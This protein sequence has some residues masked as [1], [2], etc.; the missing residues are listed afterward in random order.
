MLL[1]ALLMPWAANAQTR[2]T[3]TFDFEDGAIP[4]T[5][6]NDANYP[7]V[8]VSESQGSGHSGTYCIKS[9]NSGVNSSSST[10]SAT[11]NFNDDG[12]IS[13]LG[14]CFGEGSSTAW[15]KCIFSIDGAQQFAYGARQTW[16]TYTFNV[17][18]G[19]HTFTWSFTKDGSVNAAGDAFFVDDIVVDLGEVPAC[20][21]P[22]GLAVSNIDG[23]SATINWTSE[24]SAWVVAYK[25]ADATEFTEMD[26]TENPYTLT[27]LAPETVYQVKVQNN[28]GGGTYSLFTSPVSFTTDVACPAPTGLAAA[29]TLGNG[30]VATLSWTS[31][32]S[33]WVVAYKTAD[34]TDFTEVNVTE[35]PYTLT[36]LTPETTYNAKVKAVCG[37]ED[38][39]SSW[40][41]TITFTPTDAYTLTVNDGTTTNAYV[42]FYGYY[43]DSDANSQ[44]IIPADGLS[45]MAWG[46]IQKLTFYSSAASAVWNGAV[47]DIYFSE[48]DYTTFETAALIDWTALSE[49]VYTGSVSV[50]NGKMELTLTSPYTY[51]GGNLLIGFDETSNSSNYP[52]APWYG[53]T[54]TN[55]TAVYKYSSNSAVLAKFLPKV[56]FGYTPGEAPACM[57]PTNLA[58]SNVTARTANISWTSDGNAWQIGYSTDGFVTE[59][60]VEVTE[61]PY[62]LTGLDPETDY[63]VR[64][65]TNCGG[66]T[67]SLF[68]NPVSFTTTEAC[69]AP[70]GF[71]ASNITAHTADL[72]WTGFSE[73]YTVQYRTA[74]YMN[75]IEEGFG[76][77]LP[78]GWENKTG[79]LSTIM[80]GGDLSTSSTQWVFGSNNGV[81]DN[82]ARINIYGTGRYGW[83]ITPEIN[84]GEGYGLS[85]DLALTAYSGTGAAS[86][87]CDDD[88]F[89]VLVTTDDEATW[90]ILREWNNS[91]SADVYNNIPT[92]GEN[93]SI[94]LSAYNGQ[95]VK[96]AFYGEST[97]SNNGDN[98]LHID[99][100]T[101]GTPVPAGAWQDAV[102]EGT[103]ANLSGLLAETKY[104]ATV[105][106]DCGTD[107]TSAVA[108]TTFTT[109]IACPAPTALSYANVKSTSVDLSWTTGGAEDWI[110]A[111]KKDGDTEFTEEQVSTAQVTISG[112]TVTYTLTALLEETAY[113]VKVRDNCEVSV[114][115]DGQSAWTAVVSFTTMAACSVDNVV[116]SDVTHYTATVGWDGESASGFTVKYRVPASLA[117]DGLSADF[118]DGAM[119][120]GWTIEGPGS[121]TVGTGD[122][123]ASTGAHGGTYN[124]KI[125]HSNTGNETYLV[126]PN[127]DLSGQ[128]GLNV[129]LW[130]INREWSGDIDGFGVYYR[131]NGGEWNEIFATTEA[132]STWTE[133]NEELPAGAYAA[134]VQFGFK[135][136]D[137][138][139]YGV[140]IDDI[141][142]GT[143]SV[144]PAGAWQTV[145]ATA[146]PANIEGL[147]AGT[148]YDLTVVPNCDETL[149]SAIQ[150]FTTLADNV[151]I[152]VTEG[153]WNEAG[154]WMDGLTPTLNDNA[155][156]QANATITGLATAG[157]ITI[158]SGKTLTI[159][160]GGQLQHNNSSTITA[161]VKK[162]V[163][164]YGAD[165]FNTNNGYVLLAPP[166]GK[167]I[168]QNN[169]DGTGLRNGTYDLYSWAPTTE[170]EWTYYGSDNSSYLYMSR[171][172]GYLYANQEDTEI[173]FA[174]SIYG[175]G[176]SSSASVG[177]TAPTAGTTG[178]SDWNLL[179]NPFVCNAY[180]VDA[181]TNGNALAFYKM[182]ADGNGFEAT[183]GTAIAPM[184]GIFYQAE[185]SGYVYFVRE[186][187]ATSTNPGTLNISLAQVVATRGAKGS[188]D[189]AIIRFG[190]GNTLGKFS[191]N[192]NSAKV[193]IPQN[194]ED[195]AVVNAGN[196]GEMPVNFKANENG[197]YTLSFSNSEVTFSYLHL[198][199]NMTGADVDLLAT[200]SYTFD[201]RYTDYASRFR[202]VFA[203]GSS[204]NGENFGFVNAAG[205]LSIFGIEGT[206][207]LQVMDV[208]GRVLST[209][210]FSGSYEKSLNVAAGIYMLRL[211]NGDNVRVQKMVI[212]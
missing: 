124:A 83:L 93:V 133:L 7:W 210:T 96:I 177:Y 10:I 176:S 6:T 125:T 169:S 14:G 3:Q 118:E 174:G 138:Y 108:S 64:V 147:E 123:S 49:K 66:G 115:G 106:G 127:L 136:T 189:N 153:D 191:F 88:R 145:S 65:Q 89:V 209:E 27:G 72:A 29:L 170:L 117:L 132:H 113:S 164:G 165:N 163:T 80:E 60:Y 102:V 101:C 184:E 9:G 190:E 192:E 97:V 175:S 114:A 45:D 59:Q 1:L 179:G 167:Y 201:A 76:T 162:N 51:M 204:A 23:H 92:A 130:Y 63:Q 187:A 58:V 47:F 22:T 81:F 194:G 171:G 69:P 141:T 100:V 25:T 126:T 111:Y 90:T 134:N 55:N 16:E 183:I 39:E 61:N 116:V 21:K 203:T 149:A 17:T 37:G 31:D 57:W 34:A 131:I 99:N 41:N 5:W 173:T 79:L 206:A 104:E 120:T 158:A 35:N 73:S 188:T 30:S 148:K 144:I 56:A 62:T 28:C 121:W 52:S 32:A 205:N 11:F 154:N 2:V 85:F 40:S 33:A 94:D 212:R 78:T 196:V 199:D 91:G 168:Y 77:S 142:I 181:A 53:V 129:N 150:Q 140:A 36:S 44:F 112:T 119:P 20:P 95:N 139:G 128:S 137:S 67:Y 157:N 200:P 24:A 8:V 211:T 159:A 98:N 208:N 87:T 160:D 13:F 155:Q 71:A 105:Q 161:T 152:F 135:M 146:S 70:T 12:T 178:F 166:F 198:I 107:G 207:T 151:K 109:D 48:V 156:L 4:S 182:N 185:A 75:G 82:H 46:T 110:V 202:L 103:T 86:G 50:E 197:S 18:A 19:E 15:D 122:H 84:V 68:T 42:P 195:Y 143:P 186:M 193:Y 180:L 74:A 54:Q 172:T 43:A 26:V 38:G